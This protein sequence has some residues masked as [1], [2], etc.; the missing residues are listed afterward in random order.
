MNSEELKSTIERLSFRAKVQLVLWAI[1]ATILFVYL[2]RHFVFVSD[3]ARIERLIKKGEK[4]VEGESVRDCLAILG[5]EFILIP[6]DVTRDDM[7]SGWLERQFKAFDEMS[8]R[9]KE[10]KVNVSSLGGTKTATASFDLSGT[11]K[12]NGQTVLLARSRTE[13]LRF[14]VLL[15]K[16]NGKWKVILLELPI[17]IPDLN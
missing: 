9:V 1:P 3:V 14:Q 8:L 13:P 11:V 2:A 10:I 4:A 5:P 15:S 12:W 7:A 17:D 6:D 16:I